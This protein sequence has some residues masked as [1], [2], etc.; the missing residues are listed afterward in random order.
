MPAAWSSRNR[1]SARIRAAARPATA[2]SVPTATSGAPSPCSEGRSRC[3]PAAGQSPGASSSSAR[4][5]RPIGATEALIA[6]SIERQPRRLPARTSWAAAAALLEGGCGLRM[7][8]LVHGW[9][10]RR[11]HAGAAWPAVV[12][13]G[14]GAFFR[15]TARQRKPAVPRLPVVRPTRGR[16]DDAAAVRHAHGPPRDSVG[17]RAGGAQACCCPV[18]KINLACRRD[19]R[20]RAPAGRW[21][22]LPSKEGSRVTV[23]VRRCRWHRFK[24]AP[25]PGHGPCSLARRVWRGAMSAPRAKGFNRGIFAN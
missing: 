7:A 8:D 2:P 10:V 6:S 18:R 9:A 4:Q 25:F 1:S 16:R 21:W 23:E 22:V 12:R 3:T 13:T 11:K 15:T 14:A 17:Q 20:P 5:Q 24:Q 19:S